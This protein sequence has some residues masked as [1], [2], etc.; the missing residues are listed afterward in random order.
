MK[1]MKI[2]LTL[3]WKSKHFQLYKTVV[4]FTESRLDKKKTGKHNNGPFK[5]LGTF[6]RKPTLYELFS[7]FV[8]LLYQCTYIYSVF[9]YADYFICLLNLLTI[10]RNIG[11]KYL[12]NPFIIPNILYFKLKISVIEQ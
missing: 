7:V 6:L 3:T 2:A 5:T 8:Y 10:I 11:L 1:V 4:L 9:F 12:F